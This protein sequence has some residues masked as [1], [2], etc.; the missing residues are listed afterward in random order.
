MDN[1]KNCQS[2]PEYKIDFH[3]RSLQSNIANEVR[4]NME[5]RDVIE[6]EMDPDW[7]FVPTAILSHNKRVVPRYDVINHDKENKEESKV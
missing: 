2:L 6:D 5:I 3:D 1:V 7:S 4:K